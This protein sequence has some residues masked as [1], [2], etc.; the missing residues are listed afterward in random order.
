MK[1]DPSDAGFLGR[2]NISSPVTE[3]HSLN[4]PQIF[5]YIAA[6]EGESRNPQTKNNSAIELSFALNM[7]R[8]GDEFS[9]PLQSTKI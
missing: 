2:K 4:L 3:R 6:Y 7:N 1:M 5:K 9:F 8:H